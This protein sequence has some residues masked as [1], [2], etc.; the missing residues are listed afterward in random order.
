[1]CA[2]IT[3]NNVNDKISFCKIIANRVLQFRS[4]LPNTQQ[5]RREGEEKSLNRTAVKLAE[6][7]G[8][9]M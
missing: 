7:H 9:V 2:K 8:W 3:I 4:F 1:M 5:M 6:R